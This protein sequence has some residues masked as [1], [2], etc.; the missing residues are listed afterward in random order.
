MKQ[1][2]SGL[3]YH[4]EYE[5]DEPLPAGD[6]VVDVSVRESLTDGTTVNDM[7]L[8]GAVMSMKL[9]EY[10]AIF[11]EA[12]GLLRQHGR[13]TIVVPPERAYG[14]KGLPPVI[15]PGATM[16]YMMQL[17][18]PAENRTAPGNMPEKEP[19]MKTQQKK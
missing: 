7:E 19:V 10:P 14:D 9:S 12:I 17:E 2:A 6:P 15:P 18:S 11:R 4:I 8:T 3:W 13:L 5:G 16:I 1:T